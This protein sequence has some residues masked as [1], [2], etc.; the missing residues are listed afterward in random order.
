MIGQELETF[1]IRI[2]A[3]PGALHISN[4]Y[5]LHLDLKLEARARALRHRMFAYSSARPQCSDT[6]VLN[7][8]ARTP[9]HA[10]R[11]RRSF[12]LMVANRPA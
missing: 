1:R 5:V 12:A 4:T 6:Y 11:P 8:V 10:D 2:G 7:L 3:P 9:A